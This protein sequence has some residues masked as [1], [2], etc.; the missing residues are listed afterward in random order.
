MSG[1]Q[2]R[3]L[4]ILILVLA[5]GWGIGQLFALKTV[6][7]NAPARRAE[8]ESE[9]RRL[10]DSS[11]WWGNLLTFD[12]G[13]FTSKLQQADPLL[14]NITVRRHWFH[15][16]V[17]TATLKQPSLGWSTGNQVYVLD[18]DGTVIG[19]QSGASSFPV[20][21]DGSNLPV[22]IGQ[23]AASAHFVEF[24]G[25]I[26]PA[27]A[28]VGIGVTRLDIKDTTL[29]LTAQTNKGYKL[30]FD[31]GRT[32]MEELSDLRAVQAL[33]VAQKRTPAEYIDLRIA[34]KAY[35]K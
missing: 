27:L 24:V 17:I 1:L 6:T 33:L 28:A 7:V 4:V 3:L 19:S 10:I 2:R 16:V 34:G 26:V 30:F 35:Y 8:I 11:W 25:Q 9:A 5:G 21:V 20:V 32:V 13:E 23:K 15:A 29:D 12:N 31:T 22:R 18:S 14:R